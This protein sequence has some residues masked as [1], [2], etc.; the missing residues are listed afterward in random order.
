MVCIIISVLIN[1]NYRLLLDSGLVLDAGVDKGVNGCMVKSICS[2]K[3]IA[4]DGRVQ[5]HTNAFYT[6]LYSNAKFIELQPISVWNELKWTRFCCFSYPFWRNTIRKSF[7]YQNL[8]CFFD[9]L[10]NF[11]V[12]ISEFNIFWFSKIFRHFI[13]HKEVELCCIDVI[14]WC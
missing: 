9:Y 11:T 1:E 10:K 2:K 13:F 12:F 14:N 5:V 7:E 4:K 8:I 6:F 3:A